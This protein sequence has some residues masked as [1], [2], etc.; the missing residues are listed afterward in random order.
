MTA[1]EFSLYD[2][3][4]E[5]VLSDAHNLAFVAGIGSGKSLAGAVRA[6]LA[7]NGQVGNRR[8]PT[9]NLGMVTAPTYT[10]LRDASLRTYLE[11]AGGLV[12]DYNR[13]E[14]RVVMANGSEVLFRSTERPERLRG[15]NLSWWWADEAGLYV[16]E[17]WKIGVGRLRQH[18]RGHAW[19]TTTPRGR[20]W[21]WQRFA[22]GRRG[23]SMVKAATW[24][25]PFLD[26]EFIRGL[27]EEYAGDFARQE[28]N[29]DFV[30]FEGLVYSEFER[31][32]HVVSQRPAQWAYALGGIDHGW[33]NPGV[34]LVGL[35][36]YDG[37]IYIVHEEYE[38]RRRVEDWARVGMQLTEQ[39]GVQTW[40]SD[41]SEPDFIR[42]YNEAGMT[43]VNANNEVNAGIQDVKSMLAVRRDGRPR[44]TF[45]PEAVWTA[46]EMEQYQWLSNREGLRDQVKKSNDHAQDALRYL[47]R[48]ALGN[49]DSELVVE[50]GRW[51]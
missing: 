24:E 11:I 40:Y 30:A 45:A 41:P 2:K 9:P 8:I 6:L 14:S 25:N 36:D 19:V 49:S 38:R 17:T 47:V 44:L 39:W 22:Q 4:L 34:M 33:T 50:S 7:A 46:S 10:M 51:A 23:Y 31:G 26:E 13:S 16:S 29:G 1:L 20:N 35:V 48:G 21:L 32:T 5:F 15:P 27:M 28:L 12:K 37:R 43:V 42:Q 18:G 3:Q